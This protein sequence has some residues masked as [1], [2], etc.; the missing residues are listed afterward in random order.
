MSES[1]HDISLSY[2]N[3]LPDLMCKIAIW[4]D[5]TALNSPSDKP[6]DLLHQAEIACEL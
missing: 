3:C 4:T 2:S 1:Y 5:D 6:S